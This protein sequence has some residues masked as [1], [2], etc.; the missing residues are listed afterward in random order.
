MQASDRFGGVDLA[1]QGWMGAC[2]ERRSPI[3]GY[4][5]WPAHDDFRQTF[6]ADPHVGAGGASGDRPALIGR[7]HLAGGAGGAAVTCAPPGYPQV[8]LNFFFIPPRL[9]L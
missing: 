4:G 3:H 5:G 1:G 8:Q 7:R 6:S 2:H 9:E